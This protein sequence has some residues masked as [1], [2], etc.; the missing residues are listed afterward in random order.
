MS[1]LPETINPR[2][3][4]GDMPQE[5]IELHARTV[6]GCVRPACGLSLRALRCQSGHSLRSASKIIRRAFNTLSD[7]E[8]CSSFPQPGSTSY[9]NLPLLLRGYGVAPKLLVDAFGTVQ[10]DES[11]NAAEYL[12]RDALGIAELE[13]AYMTSKRGAVLMSITRSAV[14]GSATHAQLWL[15]RLAVVERE[16]ME[17]KSITVSASNR[18]TPERLL[19]MRQ[20]V[21]ATTSDPEPDPD[22]EGSKD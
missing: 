22:L 2:D 11:L 20:S 1:K 17:R 13:L 9:A 6:A 10:L 19:W 3:L 21:N 14:N 5:E 15:D 7:W 4:L 18:N 12:S 8:N 16:V